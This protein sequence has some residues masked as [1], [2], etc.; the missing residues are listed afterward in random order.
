MGLASG[1]PKRT[2]K[3]TAKLLE[4]D[5]AAKSSK[6]IPSPLL[7]LLLLIFFFVQRAR[8]PSPSPSPS[9]SPVK[10]AKTKRAAPAK[11]NTKGG[12]RKKT[13]SKAK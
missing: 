10:K 9:P 1:K 6:V 13:T 12:S 4:G 7:L 3:K 8:T 2:I 5:E 11:K